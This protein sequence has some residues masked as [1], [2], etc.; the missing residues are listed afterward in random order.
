MGTCLKSSRSVG[1]SQGVLHPT[2][3]RAPSLGSPGSLPLT[4]ALLVLLMEI[5]DACFVLHDVEELIVGG[6]AGQAQ[7]HCREHSAPFVLETFV[8]FHC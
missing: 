2:E 7:A 8:Y 5:K 4:N 6:N 1:R 3:G